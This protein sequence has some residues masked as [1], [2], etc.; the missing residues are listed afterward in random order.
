[1][2]LWIKAL[3]TLVSLFIILKI[4]FLFLSS[5]ESLKTTKNRVKL[6]IAG[7]LANVADTVGIGSFAVLIACNRNWNLIDDKRLLGSMNGHSVL[8]AMIQSLLFLQI[9]DIDMLT[10]L[11]L[12]GASCLGGFTGGFFVSMFSKQTLRLVMC[13]G[14]CG[15]ALLLLLNQ[16]GF[17]P[18]SGEALALEGT[19]LVV[20]AVAMYFAGMLPSIG[21]GLYV[22]IQMILFLL[23]LSPLTA[24]PIM[25]TAGCIVQASTAYAFIV[26]KEI[27]LAE[28][29]FLTIAGIFGVF[30]AVPMIAYVSSSSLRWLLLAIIV[31]N[32]A[33]TW[34]N[35]EKE[36]KILAAA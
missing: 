11:T 5:G 27:A 17:A 31:Y 36:K 34:K 29:I 21:V 8:P 30:L 12:I 14:F 13:G 28:T 22:P 18:L 16:L 26:K 20:G 24:F 6:C 35:Y 23:G 10:L 7:F 25:T 19:Q 3:V 4:V 15:I 9:V 1:M 2:D 32:A 33:T